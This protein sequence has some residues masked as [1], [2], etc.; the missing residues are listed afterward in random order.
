MRPN[1]ITQIT[2]ESV[3]DRVKAVF[4]RNNFQNYDAIADEI[5]TI[6]E[7]AG[8]EHLV[9]ARATVAYHGK[10]FQQELEALRIFREQARVV[11]KEL[12]D[13]EGSVNDM[14]IALTQQKAYEL[15]GMVRVPE[16]EEV[17]VGEF[18]KIGRVVADLGKASVQQKLFQQ[19][20]R[21][22]L[23][24]LETEAKAGSSGLDIDTLRRVQ[25]ELYGL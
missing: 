16:G 6:L 18:A 4:I 5:E 17:G 3:R 22:K 13:D 14:L 15:L 11:A 10:R 12:G 19:K 9:R 23:D 24:A 7:A 1:F 2:D 25:Q 21:E 20:I 8:L